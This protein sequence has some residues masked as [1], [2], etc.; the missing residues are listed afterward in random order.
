MNTHVIT[1]SLRPATRAL[2]TIMVPLRS[3]PRHEHFASLDRLNDRLLADIG[4][5]RVRVN[6]TPARRS[7]GAVRSTRIDGS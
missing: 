7:V 1:E 3:R 5:T 4:L 6:G 2:V